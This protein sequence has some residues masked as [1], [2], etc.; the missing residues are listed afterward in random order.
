MRKPLYGLLSA[1]KKCLYSRTNLL[2]G[3]DIKEKKERYKE[4][5]MKENIFEAG[6]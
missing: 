6:T 1:I 5:E 2:N 3:K 4:F